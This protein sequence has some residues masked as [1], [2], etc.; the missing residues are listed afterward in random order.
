MADS[1]PET[2][3]FYV[4]DYAWLEQG[5]I[6]RGYRLEKMQGNEFDPASEVGLVH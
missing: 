1:V 5:F 3:F 4:N 2:L 6:Y